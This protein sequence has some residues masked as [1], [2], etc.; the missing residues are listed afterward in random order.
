[1]RKVE[2]RMNEKD[3]YDIIVQVVNN[4]MTILTAATRLR[5][6]ER[7]IYRLVNVYKQK[8]KEGF[9]HGNRD[10]KPST[11]I[12]DEVKNG[13]IKLYKTKYYNCNITHFMELINKYEN[14]KISYFTLYNLLKTNSI[15]SPKCQRITSKNY[16]KSIK[17]KQKNS[18]K[19]SD[20]EL[21]Y[22]AETNLDENQNYHPRK[23]RKK[24]YGELIQMDACND[25]WFGEDKSYLHA[26]ID[27][28]TG[29]ILALY[30]DSQETLNGY[31]HLF[32]DILTREGIPTEFLTDN[33]TVFNYERHKYPKPENDTL[34]QFSY[35]CS[36]LGTQVT[37]SSI[38]QVKGRVERLF[39]T[40]LS[41]LPIELR[42]AGITD[43]DSANKFLNSY[44]EDFNNKFAI[45]VDYTKSVFQKQDDINVINYALS[46]ITPR[47]VDKGSTI[48][49]KNKYYQ[50]YKDG[51]LI[52]VAPKSKCM[53]MEAYNGELVAGIGNVIYDLFLFERNKTISSN[54]DYDLTEEAKP[55]RV[56]KPSPNHPWGYKS[57]IKKIRRY[58]ATLS[59]NS[60]SIIT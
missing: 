44:I 10:R 14:I 33:R 22:I 43:I 42:I 59:Y 13:I 11:T 32:Y 53:V 8:G 52:C 38:P 1:M 2:L 47:I 15:I 54:F 7:S 23:S 26:A 21:I 49:Y 31:Y 40:L 36:V 45:P 24:Y 18:T 29:R 20:T 60:A 35:A 25:H 30:F 58:Y 55:K 34:T 51:S 56:Y 48:K 4:K 28:A 41:R 50:F 16:I 19:L 12:S 37:T 17:E 9:I 57:Y 6:S 46:I 27:D 39:N 5:L 3:K